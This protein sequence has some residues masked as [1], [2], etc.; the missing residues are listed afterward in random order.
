MQKCE[1]F[2]KDRCGVVNF[3]V[4]VFNL[5]GDR[6]LRIDGLIGAQRFVDMVND[7]IQRVPHD[8]VDPT[9]EAPLN[10]TCEII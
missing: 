7:M 8:S 4:V 6:I 5:R 3:Q 1:M 2:R 10:R 9:G